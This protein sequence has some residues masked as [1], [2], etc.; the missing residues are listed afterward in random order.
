M[1][2]IICDVC[3]TSYSDTTTQCPICG[4]VHQGESMV[5]NQSSQDVGGYTYVKGGRFSKN[6]VKKRNKGS[7]STQAKDESGS[8]KTIGLIIVL[9]LLIVIVFAMIA[10]ILFGFMRQ[11]PDSEND[12]QQQSEP[13][14]V[15]CT[16]LTLSQ[17]EVV[18]E[19]VGAQWMLYATCEPS[20]TTDAVFYSIDKPEVATVSE[21]GSVICVSDGTATIT[22]QCGSQTKTCKVTCSLPTEETQPPTVAPEGVHLNRISIL[23]D[24]EGYEWILYSG[25][26]PVTDITWSSDDPSVATFVDGVV[27]AVGEGETTVYADYNGVRTSCIIV[28]DFDASTEIENGEQPATIGSELILYSQYGNALFYNE[29]IQ[30]YDVMIS[31][32]ESVGLYL[33]D[34]NG[35][36]AEVSWNITQGSSCEKDGEYFTAIDSRS[37]CMVEAEY[38]GQI[39]RCLIRTKN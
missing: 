11:E 10:V 1:S 34:S 28:C 4:S 26:V 21:N 31:V 39:Y 22:V 6:N 3:G 37:N 24:F 7:G 27:I 9:G 32:G 18:L 13:S 25:K 12:A 36:K 15:A 30:A 35:M 16:S 2:K 29:D 38:N 14:Y 20:N 23:A 8:K 5:S 17:Y 19:S 33:K